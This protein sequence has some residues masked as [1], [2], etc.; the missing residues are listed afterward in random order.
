M[1]NLF[2]KQF[3]FFPNY[4]ANVKKTASPTLE[5]YIA[6]T[7]TGQEIVDSSARIREYLVGQ[8]VSDGS[9]C[10]HRLDVI[11]IKVPGIVFGYHSPSRITLC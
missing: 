8:D 9:D 4:Y 2:C 5:A 6:T 7:T 10:Q 11:T 3:Y 1:F